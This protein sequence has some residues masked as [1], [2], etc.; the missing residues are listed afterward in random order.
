M[1]TNP[2]GLR[3][4]PKAERKRTETGTW[5]VLLDGIELFRYSSW[6]TAQADVD[7]INTAIR[8]FYAPNRRCDD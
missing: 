5:A 4:L 8:N 6:N 2:H 7:R 1:T 3:T